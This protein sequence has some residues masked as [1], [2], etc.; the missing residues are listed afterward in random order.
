MSGRNVR[1]VSSRVNGRDMLRMTSSCPA[2]QS[3]R[4]HSTISHSVRNLGT[5]IMAEDDIKSLERTLHAVFMH[6][7]D[8]KMGLP[9]KTGLTGRYAM[10]GHA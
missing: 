6:V 4:R 2:F 8:R 5:D 1:L 7:L 10:G 9:T 3:R